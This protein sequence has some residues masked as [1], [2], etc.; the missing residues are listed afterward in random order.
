MNK[1]YVGIDPG[2]NGA[3][4][5]IWTDNTID[6]YKC[7]KSTKGMADLVRTITNHCSI[8]NNKLIVGIEKVWTLPRD[9]R[10]GAFTFGMN[11]GMWHGILSSHNI[12]P[13]LILPRKWQSSL[14]QYEIPKDYLEK[15]RK[16]KSIAQTFVKFK[17]TLATADAILITKYLKEEKCE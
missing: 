15:K 7:P 6:A 12:N 5:A 16:F 3:L 11:Y 4:C 2:I 10:K 17:V 13:I 1:V 8:K 9:G 14:E